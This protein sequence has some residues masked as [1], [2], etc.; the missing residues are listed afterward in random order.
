[1]RAEIGSRLRLLRIPSRA[2]QERCNAEREVRIIGFEDRLM[3]TVGRVG[4]LSGGCGRHRLRT[5]AL[6]CTEE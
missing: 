1:M 2:N 4:L 3:G 6:L 5:L